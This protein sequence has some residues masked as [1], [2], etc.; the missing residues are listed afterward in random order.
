MF[1]SSTLFSKTTNLL[2]WSLITYLPWFYLAIHVRLD[3][4]CCSIS[5]CGLFGFPG[6]FSLSLSSQS[7]S[8]VIG[9]FNLSTSDQLLSIIFK[10]VKIVCQAHFNVNL[11]VF[12]RNHKTFQELFNCR[13]SF[14]DWLIFDCCLN[15]SK[16][17]YLV[18]VLNLACCLSPFSKPLQEHSSLPKHSYPWLNH[19]S[20]H[21][22]SYID[23]EL[24]NYLLQLVD[25]H[26]H[27]NIVG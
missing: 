23:F 22:H 5:A 3:F 16:P 12:L 7:F 20:S 18:L 2:G 4:G 6:F 11:L 8:V 9:Y 19:L 24:L 27:N 14:M 1:T 25:V 17:E 10:I 21:I 13:A 15:F 26:F